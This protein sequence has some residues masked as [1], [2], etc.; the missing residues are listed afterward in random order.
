MASP[1]KFK[2]LYL[3]LI[4]LSAIL[5]VVFL[6]GYSHK[7]G[8]YMQIAGFT[9]GTTYHITYE[10]KGGED[11]KTS[12]DSLLADFDRSLSTYLPTSLISRFNNNEKGLH[13]DRKFTDVFIKSY[14]VFKK[15]DGAFDIT[16]APIVNALGFGT[17]K[18]TLNVDSTMIDSLLQYIGMV[19][20]TFSL[21]DLAFEISGLI[22]GIY[23]GIKITKSHHHE[24]IS[25]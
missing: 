18:D 2:K 22:I 17:R 8:E 19:K 10:S 16:V 7:K 14:E 9:Q 13:A 5:L 1:H 25:S 4:I 6:I 3:Q 23:T 21:V 24:K 15:T 12:I 20:G 11:L